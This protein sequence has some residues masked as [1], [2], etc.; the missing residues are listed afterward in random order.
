MGWVFKVLCGGLWRVLS[1][2]CLIRCWL[3]GGWG[4]A[5][6]DII[7]LKIVGFV[8]DMGLGGAG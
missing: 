6:F 5:L 4:L 2:N 7:A 3:I 8:C 1:V